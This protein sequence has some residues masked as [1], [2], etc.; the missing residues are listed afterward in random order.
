MLTVKNLTGFYGRN[1]ILN[2]INFSVDNNE[3]VSIVG[4]NGSGKTTLIRYISTMMLPK[5]GNINLNGIEYNKKNLKYLRENISILIDGEQS[6]YSN[7]TVKQNIKYCVKIFNI[8]YNELNVKI[9]CLMDKLCI[10]QY[11]DTVVSKLSKGN[12]QKVSILISIIKKSKI[13]ILDEPDNALDRDSIIIL[14]ELLKEEKKYRSIVLIS[15]DSYL[16]ENISD[17]VIYIS[18]GNI[19][20]NTNNG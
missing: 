17:K 14:E 10:T 12:R 19:E 7:L 6:L 4:K 16:V 2:N 11:Q 13:L 20:E 8:N 5:K 18:D 15:H 1:V 9:K 3:I